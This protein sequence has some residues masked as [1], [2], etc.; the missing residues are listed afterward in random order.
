MNETTLDIRQIV[1]TLKKR[2]G[3][4]GKIFFLFVVVAAV[5]SMLI[6]P[7]YEGE[8]L[9]RVKQPKGLAN[10]LLGDIA[11]GSPLA[12]KQLMSTYAEI[13]K[14]RVVVEK[15]IAENK[16]GLD[17]DDKDAKLAKYQ[18]FSPRITTQPVRDTERS[19]RPPLTKLTTSLR[20]V[21]GR[22]KPGLAS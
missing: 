21:L 7:T 14:S 13:L 5:V 22:M 18:D 8:L 3:L 20:R 6:P 15:T 4:I 19:C 16:I 2:K 11:G 12:T 17:K 10:S 9:L 1:K